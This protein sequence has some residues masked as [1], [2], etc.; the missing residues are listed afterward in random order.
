MVHNVDCPLAAYAA[1]HNGALAILR[2]LF[3]IGRIESSSWFGNRTKILGYVLQCLGF[4]ELAS[5]NQNDVVRLIVFAIEILKVIDW[6]SFDI[7]PVADGALAI[8]VP[9]VS[10]GLNPLRKNSLR[11]VFASFEFIA[12]H[13][14]L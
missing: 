4:F 11:T 2:W 6:H 8:V 1:K 9:F 3:G 5:D 7:G 13:G 10:D 14:E 12:N